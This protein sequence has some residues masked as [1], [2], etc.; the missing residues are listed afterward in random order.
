MK[1]LIDLS[2]TLEHGMITYQGLPAPIICGYL[3]REASKQKYAE[4][5]T[6][7]M[8]KI[9]MISNNGTYG[10]RPFHRY[11]DGKALSELPLE[12]LVDLEGL[13]FRTQQRVNGP[14]LFGRTD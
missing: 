4:G 7:H 11:A 1:R 14:D 8:G 13:V 5:T 10:E 3:S 12:S 6:F 2:H 9:E